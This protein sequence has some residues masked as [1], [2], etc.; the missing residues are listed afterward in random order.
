MIHLDSGH[1][2]SVA[3]TAVAVLVVVAAIYLLYTQVLC[4]GICRLDHSFATIKLAVYNGTQNTSFEAYLATTQQE[5]DLGYMN[6]KTLGNNCVMLSRAGF[7]DCTQK[8]MLFAFPNQSSKC[9]WMEN[10]LIPLEQVWIG[11]NGMIMAVYDAKPLSTA[12]VCHNATYVLETNATYMPLG[13]GEHV[14]LAT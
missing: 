2:K 5:W 6:A 11:S 9:F 12:S 13:I 3:K 4:S 1:T 8:G 14:S 10:T 7:D